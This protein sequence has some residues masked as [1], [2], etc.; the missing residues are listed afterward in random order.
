MGLGA[1]TDLIENLHGIFLKG[2]PDDTKKNRRSTNLKEGQEKETKTRKTKHYEIK[3]LDLDK[4]YCNEGDT[5]VMKKEFLKT[6]DHT[7]VLIDYCHLINVSLTSPD[8]STWQGLLKKLFTRIIKDYVNN[9]TVKVLYIAIDDPDFVPKNKSIE[10]EKRYKDTRV[11]SDYEKTVICEK[12][13]D[14]GETGEDR[15]IPYEFI[16]NDWTIEQFKKSLFGN[17]DIRYEICNW[18]IMHLWKKI[19]DER[20]TIH[21]TVETIKVGSMLYQSWWWKN[22]SDRAYFESNK[23]KKVRLDVSIGSNNGANP[24]GSINLTELQGEIMGEGE[25]RIIK[26]IYSSNPVSRDKFVIF[27]A[28]TDLLAMVL[29][30]MPDNIS[31]A[32]DDYIREIYIYGFTWIIDM[33][34]LYN[35]MWDFFIYNSKIFNTINPIETFILLML[36]PGTDYLDSIPNIGF[37]KVLKS[38]FEKGNYI[39]FSGMKNMESDSKKKNDVN[40]SKNIEVD[41]LLKFPI[42]TSSSL[43]KPNQETLIFVDENCFSGFIKSLMTTKGLSEKSIHWYHKRCVWQINYWRNCGKTIKN[44]VNG[45]TIDSAWKLMDPLKSGWKIV[46]NEKKENCDDNN[47]NNSGIKMLTDDKP[48]RFEFICP[49]IIQKD[50]VSK[51]RKKSGENEPQV[52]K[53]K[54]E[55]DSNSK[56]LKKSKVEK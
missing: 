25:T 50:S 6:L 12:L 3:G 10:Q 45:T 18:S 56:T 55:E 14:I 4:S 2:M 23:D 26:Y 27:S 28:D 11:L 54:K 35:F 21:L 49:F 37:K 40:S 43:C 9:S 1:R 8:V 5:F 47:N 39:H 32:T 44:D 36:I 30:S 34:R 48:Y 33:N 52:R 15:I 22:P 17:K 20:I 24:I 13:K 41:S 42:R 31:L 51:P 7:H 29:L 16:K 46:K 19:I 53:K 38:Y